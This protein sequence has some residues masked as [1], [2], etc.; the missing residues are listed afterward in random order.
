MNPEVELTGGADP[1]L[2]AAIIA[3]VARLEEERAVQAA[4]P[5]RPPLQGRWVRSGR[6]RDVMLPVAR[7][8]PVAE[9]W[10]V[11]SAEAEGDAGQATSVRDS[12][13]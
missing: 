12:G 10:S 3:A 13:T 1:L 9:G 11:G 7:P 5:P 6:P 2:S 8:T 4:N